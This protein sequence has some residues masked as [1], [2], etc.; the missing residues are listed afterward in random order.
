[1]SALRIAGAGLAALLPACASIVSDNKSV[2]YVET[3][4]EEARCELHGQDFKR[5]I[6]TPAS[7]QLPANAAPVM[8]ACHCRRLRPDHAGARH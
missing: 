7:I 8:V 5:V 4:P 1:M 3:V 6:T 2:T